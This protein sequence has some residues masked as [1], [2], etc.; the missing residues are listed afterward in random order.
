MHWT[1]EHIYRAIAISTKQIVFIIYNLQIS[2]Y[3]KSFL[4]ET[5]RVPA[6]HQYPCCFCL[7]CLFLGCLSDLRHEVLFHDLVDVLLLLVGQ[8]GEG[9]SGDAYFITEVRADVLDGR[10]EAD[11]HESLHDGVGFVLQCSG[12]LYS[13]FVERMVDQLEM[14]K[15]TVER[16]SDVAGAAICHGT[17]HGL[18][19]AVEHLQL[20]VQPHE[21]LQLV[22]DLVRV[23]HAPDGVAGE[24]LLVVRVLQVEFPMGVAREVVDHDRKA[25]GLVDVGVVACD[26]LR[27]VAVVLR[28]GRGD[29]RDTELLGFLGELDGFPGGV[30]AHMG[31]D[32]RFL[33]ELAGGLEERDPLLMAQEPAFRAGATDEEARRPLF[34]VAL[35]Q[36]DERLVVDAPV[37]FIRR[38]RRHVDTE[39]FHVCFV[40]SCSIG[41][42]EGR[43]KRDPAVAGSP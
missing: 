1:N 32:V 11:F 36:L 12:L 6:P 34:Q 30:G 43:D 25:G 17:D 40:L 23:L 10:E 22:D 13:A 16:R 18:V 4:S 31:D 35:H 21:L 2:D 5:P 41:A 37:L 28:R 8:G 7:I 29:F 42:F 39:F 9:S 33:F 24:Q 15:Q 3:V 38:D 27:A 20:R 26:L 14:G 19:V